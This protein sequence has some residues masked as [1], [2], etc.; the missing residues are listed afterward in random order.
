[1]FNARITMGWNRVCLEQLSY[2]R[3]FRRLC[4][5]DNHLY[6]NPNKKRRQSN[7]PPLNLQTTHRHLSRSLC[8]FPRSRIIRTYLL[9]YISLSP[10]NPV[11][12]YFQA[13]K[14]SA[15]TE[16]GLQLLPL[17]V[18]F[19]IT[20]LIV[21]GIVQWWGYYTPFIIIGSA[22][23]TIGAGL[24]L[25]F[26]V[27]Q[28]NWRA[29]GIMIVAGIGIGMSM[30]NAF[31]SV[32]AVLPQETLSIGNAVIMFAQTLSYILFPLVL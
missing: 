11:P 7:T 3:P 32:Q 20:G 22:I 21:G 28:S 12:I 19:V 1:M 16:S 26:A 25:L 23:Y 13:I 18:S 8:Y 9:Q 30:Q 10:T 27:D 14:G 17:M 24:M 2:H 15:P 5:N 31:M 6:Y 29:Y 4:S